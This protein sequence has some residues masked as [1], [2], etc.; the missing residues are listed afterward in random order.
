MGRACIVAI[1]SRVGVAEG[2]EK[3]GLVLAS[4]KKEVRKEDS[5]CGQGG[6]VGVVEV[7]HGKVGVAGVAGFFRNKGNRGTQGEGRQVKSSQ[8][9]QH[10]SAFQWPS[11][12]VRRKGEGL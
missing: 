2:T 7:R 9:G 5:R 1:L 3:G 6:G 4:E 10:R 11:Q 12:S 8:F